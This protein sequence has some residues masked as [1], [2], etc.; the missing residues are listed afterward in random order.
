MND[1]RDKWKRQ[2]DK[3]GGIA[4]LIVLSAVALLTIIST[5]IQFNA[6][7]DATLA[8][9]GRDELVAYYNAKSAIDVELAILR[10]VRQA[11][12]MLQQ[13]LPGLPIGS[14]VG[15]VPV[16]CGLVS[17]LV[18]L[19]D[20]DKPLPINGECSAKAVAEKGKIDVNRLGN[21]SDKFRI[22]LL[23]L[24]QLSD[25]RFDHYFEEAN[26]NGDRFTRE[27]L[28]QHLGDYVD[29]DT[30]RDGTAGSDEDDVYARLKERYRVK[31]APYD[32]VAELQLVFG[33]DDEL[34][35][36]LR[37]VFT[38]YPVGGVSIATADLAT[39]AAVI[40][41]AA[42]NPTDPGLYG[43]P[44]LALLGQ[45]SEL[46]KLPLAGAVN[47]QALSALALTFGIQL[48]QQKIRDLTDDS[49]SLDWYTIEATG[50]SNAVEKRVTAT[51][52]LASNQLVYYREE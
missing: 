35:D 39:I 41:Q 33:I 17:Q 37:R 20:G 44:M 49:N 9:N 52:N 13:M 28:V 2:R 47:G 36:V 21:I 43:D 32:S 42:A 38:V 18:T 46:R 23:L 15:M 11:Q 19:E 51:Y 26:A 27:E 8:E 34:F 16:E 5:D 1:Q 45:I 22:R 10:A 4:L 12:S 24:G 6:R 25:P 48:D 3:Q 14:L 7:V 40:R 29:T 50:Q 30:V 31:N